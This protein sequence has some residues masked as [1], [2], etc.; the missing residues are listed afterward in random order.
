M[1]REQWHPNST[2]EVWLSP[3]LN[4]HAFKVIFNVIFNF[5]YQSLP[6][7]IKKC[8][9][10]PKNSPWTPCLFFSSHIKLRFIKQTSYP[11]GPDVIWNSAFSDLRIW[12]LA[13]TGC[14]SQD[15][16]SGIESS[17]HIKRSTLKGIN[18][19]IKCLT[20][21]W[22]SSAIVQVFWW[23][24]ENFYFQLFVFQNSR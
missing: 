19:H 23:S 14:L 10:D 9:Q 2:T 7:G 8:L 15:S 1:R 16:P 13:C 5:Q 4:K 11:L 12:N 6:Q 18:T 20:A 21:F 3:H 22:L 17:T 24:R